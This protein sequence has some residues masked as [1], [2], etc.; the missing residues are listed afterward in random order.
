MPSYS[1]PGHEI[2]PAHI[3]DI[4]EIVL[5]ENGRFKI[6]PASFWR[7]TSTNERML[8]AHQ[9]GIYSYPTVELVERLKEIIAGRSAIE[10]G[11]GNGVLAETL[12]IPAT[13]SYQQSEEK[14]R[15]IY[16]AI[17]QELVPYGP[18]VEKLSAYDAVRKYDPQVVL[19]CWVTHK[20]NKNEPWRKGNEV[21]I[22]E[23]DILEHCE[24]YLFVGNTG[25][26][27]GHSQKPIWQTLHTSEKPDYLYSRA[28]DHKKEF[29]GRW[30]GAKYL[31]E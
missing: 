9:T 10:I 3:R 18:N 24:E 11:A 2:K 31:Q 28:K 16:G 19:G 30:W 6:M 25:A 1:F 14:Y 21:G 4:R 22:D 27:T 23:L 20:F 17:D 5:D 8:F 29:L 7:G 26:E 13:D 15:K 12:G